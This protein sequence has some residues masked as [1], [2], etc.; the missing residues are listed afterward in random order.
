MLVLIDLSWFMSGGYRGINGYFL[1]LLLIIILLIVEKNQR[2]I[3]TFVVVLNAISLYI[4]EYQNPKLVTT[5]PFEIDII[6][7]CIIFVLCIIA[8]AV[9]VVNIKNNYDQDR[10]EIIKMNTQ[11][12]EQK[13]EI[14]SKN[15]ELEAYSNK[16][17]SEV[18][19]QTRQ[20]AS[21]NLELTEQNSSL[22]QFTYILSHNIRSPITQ[23]KSLFGLIPDDCSMDS[24]TREVLIRM[25]NSTIKL[26]DIINDLSK[27]VNV[28]KDTK[29]ILE[30]VSVGKQ[31]RL[32]ISTLETQIQASNVDIDISK[33]ED[34]SMVGINAYMQSIFYNLIHNAIKY[35]ST[36]RQPK[37]EIT[38]HQSPENVLIRVSDNGIGIDMKFAKSKIFQLYQRFATDR[39][40]KGFGL[41][42]IKTQVNAMGGDIEVESEV[43]VGT[44]FTISI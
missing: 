26:E 42:L 9:I 43:G 40:G 32:A 15:R 22:E 21:L 2:H 27:I 35:A 18:K 31:L 39:E 14:E 28:R 3:Y 34:V 4:I 6:G 36:D 24:M 33:V 7:H 17:K 37:I 8:A 12:S 44:T 10:N 23:L 30:E 16:L 41:F 29:E 25:E 11:L 38:V 13:I 20:L 5:L 1:I 19:L